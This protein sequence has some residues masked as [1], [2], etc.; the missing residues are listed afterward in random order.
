MFH[1]WQ[2]QSRK[3]RGILVLASALFCLPAL[4]QAQEFSPSELDT[5]VANIALYPDPLLVQVLAASTYGDQ[6]GPANSWAQAHRHLSGKELSNA[7]AWA[8]LP[9]DASVQ[10][11]IP[12][13]TVLA[14]MAKY[15]AWTDQLGDA[16]FM[17]KDEVMS[18]IQR[19]RHSARKYGHLV[20]DDRVKVTDG[21]VQC[22][23]NYYNYYR[24][25]N[26]YVRV[27]YGPGIW[28]GGFGYWGWGSCWF[29]W[30]PRVIYVHDRHW[31]APRRPH[32]RHY[33]PPPHR[34]HH[35]VGPDLGGHRNP[36]H[37]QT[38]PKQFRKDPPPPPPRAKQ[39]PVKGNVRTAP[40]RADEDPRKLEDRPRYMDERW[41]DRS[42][43][44]KDVPQRNNAPSGAKSEWRDVPP[45]Q[46][47]TSNPP[48]RRYDDDDRRGGGFGGSHGSSHGG[49]GK[50]F[51]RR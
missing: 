19:L 11:L 34:P 38:Q 9:Y 49:S 26:G 27:T 18:A 37:A 23:V 50:P 44:G 10:A 39:E 40:R 45:P 6:I 33:A 24:Y 36:P 22:R 15:S 1:F 21:A 4:G 31:Y 7:M 25:A 14:M 20:S 2:K 17:Q 47:G 51:G 5:L 32:H 28:I 48:P 46:S 41:D 12:F 13:P 29:D 43:F 3:L 16:V 8:K 42:S 35:K 30:G